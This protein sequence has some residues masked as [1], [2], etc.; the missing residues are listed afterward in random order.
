MS[1]SVPSAED[2]F[3]TLNDYAVSYIVVGGI[4]ALMHSS[5]YP[6]FDTDVCPETS[7]ENLDRLASALRQMNARIFTDAVPEGLPFS[8]DASFLAENPILNL[9][10]D[11][12]RVDLISM[13]AGSQG[14]PDLAR[15]AITVMIDDLPVKVAS[16]PDVI[17]TKAAVTSRDDPSLPVLREILERS[18]RR[19]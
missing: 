7:R 15:D 4:A 5:P 17:R 14:Y 11:F 13:P 3:K 9:I 19:S 6:T 16:L 8:P 1:G 12:G 10:T 18:R 2:V